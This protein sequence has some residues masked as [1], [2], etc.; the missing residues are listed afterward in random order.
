MAEKVKKLYTAV[1]PLSL[2][3]YLFTFKLFE[4]MIAASLTAGPPMCPVHPGT[5]LGLAVNSS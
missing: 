2:F 1:V 4:A 3:I 5:S